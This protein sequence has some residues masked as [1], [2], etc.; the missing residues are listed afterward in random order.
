MGALLGESSGCPFTEQADRRL[1]CITT[2]AP[3]LR[4]QS[5]RQFMP[6]RNWI[7]SVSRC[8]PRRIQPANMCEHSNPSGASAARDRVLF[9]VKMKL[10][11]PALEEDFLR[12]QM[13]GDSLL[14]KVENSRCFEETESQRDEA[15]GCPCANPVFIAPSWFSAPPRLALPMGSLPDNW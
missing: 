7:C 4:P 2:E 9:V 10:R 6:L 13:S 1:V 3:A 8:R 12:L 5:S 14:K 11:K 15:S